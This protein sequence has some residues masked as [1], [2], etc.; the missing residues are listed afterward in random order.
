MDTG[1]DTRH[2]L[3]PHGKEIPD[4][5]IDNMTPPPIIFSH[6]KAVG[7]LNL[8]RAGKTLAIPQTSHKE[9]QQTRLR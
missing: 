3:A 8:S 6:S 9:A 2:T 4:E 7:L 1:S 5:I